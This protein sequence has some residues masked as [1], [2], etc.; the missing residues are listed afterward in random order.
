MSHSSIQSLL[1]IMAKLRDPDG[2]CPWDLKQDFTSIAPHTLEEAYEVV[3]TIERKDYMALKAE[4]GDLLFQVV[5]YAQLGQEQQLFNFDDIVAGICDKLIRRHPHVFGEAEATDD[6]SL[7]YN[8]EYQ[9]SKERNLLDDKSILA[10]IPKHLPALSQA[11]KIQKRVAHVGFDWPNV[12]GALDKVAEE[13]SE[14]KE[15]LEKAPESQ[16]SAEELGD[17]LF[18]LVNVARHGGHDPE[19]LLRRANSKFCNRFRQVESLSEK[20]LEKSTLE[21]MDALWDLV[22]KNEKDKP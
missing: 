6:E 12:T 4:L 8:W 11:A 18:A 22:K 7:R 5:F 14:V 21:E 1:D 17:L 3:D 20:P 16:K 9:K 19:Q 2:G 10:D 15:E 13:F